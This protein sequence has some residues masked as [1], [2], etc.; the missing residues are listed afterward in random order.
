MHP[1]P[2]LKTIEVFASVQGEGLRQGEPTVFVRL[3]GCNLRCPFCD[4]KYAWSGGHDRTVAGIAKD[5]CR[6]RRGFPARW[7]CLTGGEPLLQDVDP[8]VRRLRADGFLI[9]IETNGILEPRPRADW[10]TV[11]P[12]PPRYAFHPAF[13]RKAREVKLVVSRGLTPARVRAL[14]LAFPARTPL[15]L[16]PQDNARWSL[17]KGMK[18]LEEAS[19]R[20]LGNIRVSA[21]LH[22]IY[23]LR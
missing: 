10:Y 6:L 14:R 16:Q 12:K 15:L 20:G 23:G 3:A 17:R 13:A 7:V 21:Q 4:T 11:S 1:P 22:K 9:Q 19:R 5:V 8:L 18:L 2:T